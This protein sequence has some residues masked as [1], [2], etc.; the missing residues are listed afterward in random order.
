MGRV[1][2]AK[3]NLPYVQALR[4]RHGHPR[5]YFRRTGC[6][7]ITLP[8]AVGSAE[9][10]AA[11][12]AA[13]S[14]QEP[15]KPVKEAVGS[16]GALVASYYRSAEYKQLATVTKATYRNLLERLRAEHGDKPVRL[17]EH[18]HIRRIVADHAETPATANGMLKVLRLLMRLAVQEGL[19]AND[20]S[21]GVPRVKSR[22]DGFTT[23]TEADIAAFEARW[24]IGTRQHLA[25]ALLLYTGQRGRSDVTRMGP[26]HVQDGKIAV[27]QNKTG[28]R[29]LIPVHARLRAAIDACPSGHLTFIATESG[30]PSSGNSFGNWFADAVRAAGLSGLAAHGLR[31]AAAR[32]LAE[33][34]CTTHEI[35]A[36]TGHRSLREVEVYT[37]AA[38][39]ERGA[40]AA[41]A[42]IK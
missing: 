12:Q 26:Q 34:G 9:F 5:H 35:A 25:L 13:L 1:T 16:F 21:I 36:V 30:K 8:G 15:P 22:S 33:A 17:I 29:L 40:D 14:G 11:Y 19:R 28:A 6:L 2:I 38:S 20:P 10:M 24:P 23:W 3:L 41:M 18:K 7:R 39:Q 4:D 32:R 27:R 37:R 31:K 42:K